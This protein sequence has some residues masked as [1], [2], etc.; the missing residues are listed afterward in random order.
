MYPGTNEPSS[1][2]FDADSVF[3]KI[4]A[5]GTHVHVEQGHI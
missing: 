5:H 3:L 2:I 4:L 1:L